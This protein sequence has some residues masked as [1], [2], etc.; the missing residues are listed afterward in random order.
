MIT[1]ILLANT[2]VSIRNTDNPTE[3]ITDVY[4]TKHNS[5]AQCSSQRCKEGKSTLVKAS[6]EFWIAFPSFSIDDFSHEWSF[7]QILYDSNQLKTESE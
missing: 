2:D 3:T 1:Q 4:N 7:P 6:A 5:H